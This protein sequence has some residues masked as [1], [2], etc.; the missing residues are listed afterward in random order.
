MTAVGR[1]LRKTSIDELPQLVNVLRGEMTLV[2]PRP[3]PCYES[4]ACEA[5]QLRRLDV[6]PGITCIWQA[7]A[8]SRVSFDEWMRMDI[9]Y[10]QQRSLL[11]DLSLLLRTVPAVLSGK[12]AN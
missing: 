4:D 8:R 2:G 6:T 9:R 5:W 11:Q 7:E 1:V 12:G 3:L 10:I